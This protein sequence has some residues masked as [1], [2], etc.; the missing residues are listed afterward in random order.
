MRRFKIGHET[1]ALYEPNLIQSTLDVR[2][3]THGFF[4][5]DNRQYVPRVIV[6]V[7]ILN[8]AGHSIPDSVSSNHRLVLSVTAKKSDGTQVFNQSRIYMQVPQYLGRGGKMGR[9]AYEKTGIVE[10][11]SL[12]PGEA[13]H[14]KFDFTLEPEEGTSGKSGKLFSE[15]EILV[16]IRQL[17]ADDA[18]NSAGHTFYETSRSV[19]IEE[20]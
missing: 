17:A 9:A 10:D 1:R 13:V 6:D 4:W 5:R 8:K 15:L 20:R 7:T 14:E 2:T 18:S 19:T 16:T 12:P 3:D 11:S